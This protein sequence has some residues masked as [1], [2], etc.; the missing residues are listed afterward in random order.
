M[1]RTSQCFN[2]EGII[3]PEPIQIKSNVGQAKGLS[4]PTT[5]ATDSCIQIPRQHSMGL[6]V[7]HGG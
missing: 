3:R 1:D 2:H 7:L 5:R 6:P 4:H